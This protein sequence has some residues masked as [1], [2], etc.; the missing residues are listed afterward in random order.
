MALTLDQAIAQAVTQIQAAL[1][2]LR[3]G[4]TATMPLRVSVWRN[5]AP[6]G[7]R[8]AGL[9]E[10]LADIPASIVPGDLDGEQ[11]TAPLGL[12][13]DRG[14]HVGYLRYGTDVRPGDEI[15]HGTERYKVESVARSAD[16][17]QISA[18][19]TCVVT[20]LSQL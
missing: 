17:A 12:A 14:D 11:V 16:D 13:G 6:A 7:G 15:R 4:H 10:V 18:W 5:P 8:T 3:I 20:A 1:P 19:S 9:V 2:S